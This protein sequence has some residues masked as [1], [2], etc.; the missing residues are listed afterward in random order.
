[1]AEALRD[2][3]KHPER[4]EKMSKVMLEHRGEIL[5]SVQIEKLLKIYED[6]I[7]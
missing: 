7:K 2:L 5:Q 3:V 6:L 1:M 4:V